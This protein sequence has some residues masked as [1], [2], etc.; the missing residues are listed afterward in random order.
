MQILNSENIVTIQVLISVLLII[1]D[2]ENVLI[3]SWKKIVVILFK[4]TVMVGAIYLL[5]TKIHNNKKPN[6]DIHLE[7]IVNVPKEMLFKKDI[8]DNKH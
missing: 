3:I 7:P 6:M 8:L 5:L 1:K 4:L 2:M